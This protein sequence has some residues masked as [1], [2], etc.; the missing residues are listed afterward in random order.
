MDGVQNYDPASAAF[1]QALVQASIAVTD[2]ELA[3]LVTVMIRIRGPMA[4]QFAS[5][6][7][8]SRDA[9]GKASLDLVYKAYAVPSAM[10]GM[11][12]QL[13]Q[14][15]VQRFVAKPSAQQSTTSSTDAGQAFML[16]RHKDDHG[17]VSRRVGTGRRFRPHL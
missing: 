11:R 7:S 12:E 16:R 6:H 10:A 15:A 17:D 2:T 13:K 1:D 14:L 5:F 8:C 4:E 3:R 9:D